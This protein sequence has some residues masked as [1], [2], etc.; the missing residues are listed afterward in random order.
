MSI[1]EQWAEAILARRKRWEFRRRCSLEPGMRVWLYATAP[2]AEI[3]GYFTVG[4]VRP[5][6]AK[7]PDPEIAHA[8]LSTLR[9]YVTTSKA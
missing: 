8:G 5:I 1:K 6:D 9:H 3:I 2:R 4:V 7:N